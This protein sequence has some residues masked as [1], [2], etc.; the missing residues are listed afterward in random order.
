MP[1]Q[2]G[3]QD[4][5]V[6]LITSDYKGA[7]EG[8]QQVQN[9][10][11]DLHG[12][13]KT[14]AQSTRTATAE[15]KQNAAATTRVAAAQTKT[16]RSSRALKQ[17]TDR[18]THSFRQLSRDLSTGSRRLDMLAATLDR[19]SMYAWK[20][21]IAMMPLQRLQFS[22]M[23]ATGA[24]VGLEAAAVNAFRAADRMKNTLI[25][26]GSS[27]EEA[28]TTVDFLL[29]KAAKLPFT[30]EQISRAAMAFRVSGL[31][32]TD[33]EMEK[34]IDTAADMA[35]AGTA[36]AHD[37]ARAA[38]ALVDAANGEFRR[39]RQT[40]HVSGEEVKKFGDDTKSALVKMVEAKWGGVAA[41]QMESLEGAFSN[42]L[43]SLRRFGIEVGKDIAP[44]LMRLAKAG[45]KFFDVL[46]GLAK[47]FPTLTAAIAMGVPAV[48]SAVI[49][50]LGLATQVLRFISLWGSAKIA[51]SKN[52]QTLAAAMVEE[53]IAGEAAA[54]A[55]AKEALANKANTATIVEQTAARKAN[56]A[57]ATMEYVSL[58]R[59]GRI[60]TAGALRGAARMT[61][62]TGIP[63][64]PK[65]YSEMG[66]V[67]GATKTAGGFATALKTAATKMA[68]GVATALKTAGSF[69]AALVAAINPLILAAV[70][71]TSGLIALATSI[72]RVRNADRRATL[73][74]VK[75]SRQRIK[76]LRG[77]G[78][79]L[80]VTAI[81]LREH[82]EQLKGE[83]E[84]AQ[85]GR[86]RI[87]GLQT[88]L[89]MTI[90]GAPIAYALRG[91]KSRYEARETAL[92]TEITSAVDKSLAGQILDLERQSRFGAAT[93]VEAGGRTTTLGAAEV[94][95]R[96]LYGVLAPS[97]QEQ[98]GDL[99]PYIK[100][101]QEATAEVNKLQEQQKRGILVTAQGVSIDRAIIQA[102]I[103]Q[104]DDRRKPRKPWLL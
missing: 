88:A 58:A 32:T 11:A 36:Q 40:Y 10:L 12:S 83:L 77:E 78:M 5:L 60:P 93:R 67:S 28:G 2:G 19:A 54:V 55:Q 9:S 34:W 86:R 52:T 24:I 48:T 22:L 16:A 4:N 29:K 97:V 18:Q 8:L 59:P 90:I 68:G 61:Q 69:I 45:A 3:Y 63:T 84:A 30:F 104:A 35:A 94:A 96:G 71:A 1:T 76:E 7:V 44:T 38:E 15:A 87:A 80:G 27:A 92:E 91:R 53:T 85:R 75:S 43:D 62:V 99:G 17:A 50:L 95:A 102:K 98:V 39:L 81:H 73:E 100:A 72:K 47:T 23:I 64:V 26:M 66:Y 46:T 6:L 82:T 41:K 57:A 13:Q 103:K 70:A 101:V 21:N 37:I 65:I 56:A 74:L 31:A 49:G 14:Q 33:R 51:L 20:F 79:M 42:F 25:G 89:T